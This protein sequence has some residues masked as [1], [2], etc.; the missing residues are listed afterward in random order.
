MERT[1]V[2]RMI[3]LGLV[4]EEMIGVGEA[5]GNTGFVPAIVPGKD[6][7]G[8]GVREMGDAPDFGVAVLRQAD[9]TA[10]KNNNKQRRNRCTD[11]Y[12]LTPQNQ[13]VPSYEPETR[14]RPSGEKARLTIGWECISRV[15]RG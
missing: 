10:N 6:A 2:P 11:T 3:G 15:R 1:G 14:M 9:D 5:V 7:V 4:G 8:E 12:C 13:R